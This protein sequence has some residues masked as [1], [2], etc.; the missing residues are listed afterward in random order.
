[1]RHPF[2][3]ADLVDM[4]CR[5][6]PDVLNRG[7]RA[8]GL[9]REAIEARFPK[10]GFGVQR[11]VPATE[12]SR[13][14]LRGEGALA[15]RRLGG[16]PGLAALGIVNAEA[17]RAEGDRA[18]RGKEPRELYRTWELLKLETWVRARLN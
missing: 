14:L 13:Q 3:D 4:L 9:V 7:G 16:V 10:L 18:L 2:W 5:T 8:K 11:K 17:A 1:M 6:H 15:W 12:Y